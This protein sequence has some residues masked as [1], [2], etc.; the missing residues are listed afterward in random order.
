MHRTVL[1]C[2]PWATHQGMVYVPLG[3]KATDGLLSKLDEVRGGS[4]WGAGTL[5]G[6]NRNPSERE[7]TIAQI[8]GKSFTDIAKKLAAP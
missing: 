6:E 2:L 3:F 1:N 5:A 8:Q 7:L 4:A